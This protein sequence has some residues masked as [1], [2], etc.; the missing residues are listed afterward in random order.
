MVI[1]SV[2]V[3][4]SVLNIVLRWLNTNLTFVDPLVRHLVFLCAFLG[5]IEA[6]ERNQNIAIDVLKRFL[7]AKKKEVFLKWLNRLTF[8]VSSFVCL[9][10]MESSYRFS[11]IEL[12]Y[13]KELFWGLT[14][15]QASMI[16][17]FGF[18]MLALKLFLLLILSFQG[19]ES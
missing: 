13:P 19:E 11:L 18:F 16:M 4:F 14:S 17:P 2:I 10:L 8:L 12:E 1:I 5:A 6:T 7:E 9:W 15:G 3:L